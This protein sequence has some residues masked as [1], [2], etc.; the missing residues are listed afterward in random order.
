MRVGGD[1]DLLEWRYSC[2][3]RGE[4]TGGEGDLCMREG[5][6]L[7]TSRKR[8]SVKQFVRQR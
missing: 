1:T 3:K 6:F 2:E 4:V 7:G 5:G 8:Q